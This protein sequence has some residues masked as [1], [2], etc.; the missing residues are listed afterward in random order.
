MSDDT[1]EL[2]VYGPSHDPAITEAH[3]RLAS[4]EGPFVVNYEGATYRV[5]SVAIEHDDPSDPGAGN[6][7]LI[8]TLRRTVNA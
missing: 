1:A 8:V 7:T 2:T 6:Y 3:Q 5:V 4:Q